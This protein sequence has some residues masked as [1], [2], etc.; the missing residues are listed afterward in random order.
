MLTVMEA[1]RNRRSIRSFKPDPVPREV[2]AL[3]LEAARLA[4]SGSNRQPWRFQVITDSAL[5][6]R[7]FDEASYGTRHILEAPLIIVCGCELLTYVR[8]NPLAPANSALVA[9]GEDWAS[10][11]PFIAD[12]EMNMAI[13]V[14]HMVLVATAESVGTCWVQRVKPAELAR[15]LNWPRHVAVILLLL[16]GYAREEPLPKPRLPID[17]ILIEPW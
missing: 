5:K 15:L 9:E 17:R 6:Q 13:A 2:V 16:A 3:M 4:P 12:G 8:G 11:K 10:L 14:E 7:V 1:I